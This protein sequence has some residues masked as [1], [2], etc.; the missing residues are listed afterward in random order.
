MPEDDDEISIDEIDESK[1]DNILIRIEGEG[2][3]DRV[4][5]DGNIII[6]LREHLASFCQFPLIIASDNW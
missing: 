4:D 6:T 5:E 3:D 1:W 2:D